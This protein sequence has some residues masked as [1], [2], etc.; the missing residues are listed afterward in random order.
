[1]KSGVANPILVV[2]GGVAGIGAALDLA[3]CGRAVHLVERGPVLG[4][5][6]AKLD[7]LYPTDHC[8]FCPLWTDIKKVKDNPLLTVHTNA[9]V[10]D[11]RQSDGSLQAIIVRKPPVIDGDL[12]IF[13]GK[14]AGLCSES[15]I[16]P[17]G[18][19]VYPPVYSVK[20]DACNGCG[21]C[22]DV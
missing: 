12:C 13:C 22:A 8:A 21:K 3:G 7:K 5:Q 9:E 11:I 1:M 2:G 19:H 20:D 10:R 6:V 17:L 14:C 4:G 18:D 16:A 15:A